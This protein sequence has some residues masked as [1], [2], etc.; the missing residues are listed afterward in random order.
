VDPSNPAYSS[1]A[2]VLFN[3]S[4]TTLIAYPPGSLTTSYTIPNSVTNIAYYALYG[5]RLTDVTIPA[6][7]TSI[8]TYAFALCG[9]LTNIYFQGNAPSVGSD[10]TEF[11]FDL[12]ATVYYLPGTMGWKTKFVGRPT[13]LWTPDTTL[14]MHYDAP[15]IVLTW[16]SGV[17]L[18]STNLV[19]GV[20]AT[21]SAA[22]SPYTVAPVNPQKFYRV[23]VN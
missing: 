1:V 20:W 22:Q 6:S 8:G 11:C 18:E 3:Q 2:G 19:G 5:C 7:V 13:A 21:N 15:N 10:S 17:L 16:S 12:N 4:Q 14:T 9:Y 23:T